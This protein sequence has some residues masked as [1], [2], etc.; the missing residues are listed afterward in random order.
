LIE[1]APKDKPNAGGGTVPVPLSA[2][3]WKTTGTAD[4]DPT[5]TTAAS[6]TAYRTVF[7]LFTIASSP[8]VSIHDER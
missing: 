2:G 1:V 4:A 5:P 7:I 8:S 6:T 3:L